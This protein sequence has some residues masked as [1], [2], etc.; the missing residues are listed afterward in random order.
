VTTQDMAWSFQA[1]PGADMG[2]DLEHCKFCCDV[3][4]DGILSLWLCCKDWEYRMLSRSSGCD[5]SD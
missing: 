4:C 3:K 5:L 2:M 1:V